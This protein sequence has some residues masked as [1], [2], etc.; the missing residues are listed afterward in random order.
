M[1]MLE[2]NSMKRLFLVPVL[3]AAL[4]G[5][6][7]APVAEP[8]YPVPVTGYVVASPPPFYYGYRP[9]GYHWRHGGYGRYGY[10]DYG[11]RH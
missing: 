5:C 3:L 8:S 11:Y 2:D 1:Q 7:V 4:G 9:W 6:V 10:R